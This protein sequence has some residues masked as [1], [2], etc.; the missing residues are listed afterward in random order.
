[1]STENINAFINAVKSSPELREKVAEIEKESDATVVA[2]KIS[3]LAATLGH[4]F[5][6]E[7]YMAARTEIRDTDLDSVAGGVYPVR[8]YRNPYDSDDR[9]EK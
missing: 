2:G 7:E 1:M 8:N 6:A 5:T 4:E 3:A 9:P